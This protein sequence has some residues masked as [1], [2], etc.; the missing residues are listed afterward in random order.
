MFETPN[1]MRMAQ[2]LARYAGDRQSLIARNV[3]NADTPGYRARDLTSFSE[4][5]Q[6][7]QPTRLRTT[8][9]GHIQPD[10]AQAAWKSRDIG[11]EAAPNGNTVSL[12]AEMVRAADVRA[13]HDLA[14]TV[15][16]S[17]LGV[18]RGAIGR[19]G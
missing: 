18:L 17:A 5:Y 12:E 7:E 16:K 2:D 6:Q 3:A 8:R 10:P 11:G 15:Y 4:T 19:G 14:L 13:D 9:A 1:V